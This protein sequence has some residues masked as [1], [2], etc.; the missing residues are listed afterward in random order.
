MKFWWRVF[1]I[2]VAFST[3]AIIAFGSLV[4]AVVPFVPTRGFAG[5]SSW[6]ML[7]TVPVAICII[8]AFVASW[9]KVGAKFKW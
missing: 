1:V 2:T 4:M 9:I 5:F 8:A 7:L 6:W 3:S